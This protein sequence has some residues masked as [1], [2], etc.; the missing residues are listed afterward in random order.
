MKLLCA[1][2]IE[3]RSEDVEIRVSKRLT[4]TRRLIRAAT[5]PPET[6]DEYMARMGRRS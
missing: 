6:A 2:R 4:F 3:P 1:G 5:R